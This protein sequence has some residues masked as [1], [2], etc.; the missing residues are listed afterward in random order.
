VLGGPV[1]KVFREWTMN[2]NTMRLWPSVRSVAATASENIR[3]EPPLRFPVKH[4][5]HCSW[6]KRLSAV[7]SNAV[8][9]G[10]ASELRQATT[11]LGSFE[12]RREQVVRQHRRQKVTTLAMFMITASASSRAMLMLCAKFR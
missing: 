1:P 11:L 4:G 3:L 7:T 10:K 8:G 2:A 6:A 12:R 9:T 5:A